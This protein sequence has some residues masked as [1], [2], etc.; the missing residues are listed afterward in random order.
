MLEKLRDRVDR[1]LRTLP[2]WPSHPVVIRRLLDLE[3]SR[4]C[5]A[6]AL[7]WILTDQ[8]M[9]AKILRLVNCPFFA[10]EEPLCSVPHASAL[11]GTKTFESLV[12]SLSGVGVFER[13]V[14][15]FDAEQYWRHG[16]AVARAARAIAEELQVA[17]RDDL[18]MTGLL[19]DA[20]FGILVELF[21]AEMAQV[22]ARAQEGE[23]LRD[24]EQAVFGCRSDEVCCKLAE[25][26]RLPSQ[27]RGL[28]RFQSPASQ[29][30]PDAAEREHLAILQIA[31][32]WAESVGL[33]LLGETLR[34]G[35]GPIASQQ[36]LD[37]LAEQL[38]GSSEGV[39]TRLA[40]VR[41]EVASLEEELLG[42]ERAEGALPG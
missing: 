16:L 32:E 8:G 10:L 14:A 28:L 21:P 38:S 18:Y 3:G 20:G 11:L 25:I 19:H 26:W 2:D 9:T 12:L 23:L 5:Q 33:G 17:D 1:G 30:L 42:L 40:G 24:A 37:G 36:I 31:D 29:R 27:V 13:R 35:I 34:G 7:R 4:I 39:L 41:V 22:L 15:G 6:D